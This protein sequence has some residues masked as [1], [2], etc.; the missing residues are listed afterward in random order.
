M[1]S[2]NTLGPPSQKVRV[3]F[4]QPPT[5][6]CKADP[7][8][9]PLMQSFGQEL[10]CTVE[11]DAMGLPAKY[12]L[13]GALGLPSVAQAA[14]CWLAGVVCDA[15][16]VWRHIAFKP[17]KTLQFRSSQTLSRQQLEYLPHLSHLK[18]SIPIITSANELAAFVTF[19][20]NDKCIIPMRDLTLRGIHPILSTPD[21]FNAIGHWHFLMFIQGDFL[22]LQGPAIVGKPDSQA[23][24]PLAEVTEVIVKEPGHAS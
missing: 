15:L 4:C 16:P 18:I 19:P 2:R 24:M 23:D 5:C 14:D 9:N 13:G 20:M 11:D 17:V 1:Q 10:K 12:H 21:V 3:T 22:P 6:G 7:G 8:A